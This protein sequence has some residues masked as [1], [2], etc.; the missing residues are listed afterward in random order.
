MS[1]E[2]RTPLNA[3]I[4]FSQLIVEEVLGPMEEPDNAATY[5]GYACDVLTSGRHLLDIINDILD[6]S[7]LEI[8]KLELNEQEC[9]IARI[10]DAAARLIHERARSNGL[11]LDVEIREQAPTR[12]IADATKLKQ[13]LINLLSN[14]VKFTAKGG[15]VRLRVELGDDGGFVFDVT[16]T[17]I[18]MNAE[19]LARA[20][21]P[22][23]Q[24]DNIYHKRFGGAGLGLSIVKALTE[25]HDGTLQIASA[26]EHGTT[27]RVSFP[28]VRIVG[29][30]TAQGASAVH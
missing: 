21:E 20:T 1:H 18:G 14:A 29:A 23:T 30:T 19:E 5:K 10:V 3:I 17:G 16:D 12:V 26:P 4:G 11:A 24:G 25:M 6:L 2:L 22:F 7:R 15:T 8:G 9:D 13:I 28:A 27:V